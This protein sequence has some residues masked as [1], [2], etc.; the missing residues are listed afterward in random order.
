[1]I[2]RAKVMSTFCLVDDGVLK[3]IKHQEDTR[4]SVSDSEVFS[5]AFFSKD[6]LSGA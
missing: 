5:V 1:M 2:M 4:Q 3:G 6:L